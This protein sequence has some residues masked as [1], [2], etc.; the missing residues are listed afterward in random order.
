[1]KT[2]RVVQ[3]PLAPGGLGEEGLMETRKLLEQF[4]KTCLWGVDLKSICRGGGVSD[5]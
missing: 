1:M 4:G 5:T 3:K 2:L